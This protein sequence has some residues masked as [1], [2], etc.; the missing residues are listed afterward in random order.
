MISRVIPFHYTHVIMNI[1]IQ[2]HTCILLRTSLTKNSLSLFVSTYT[3]DPQ[4]NF[5]KT[6]HEL[7]MSIYLK[8]QL[9]FFSN[10]SSAQL[11]SLD[12]YIEIT[13][14]LTSNRHYI[15]LPY[16]C[17][18]KCIGTDVIWISTQLISLDVLS[19]RHY[20]NIVSMSF[21]LN[22][23]FSFQYTSTPKDRK[24]IFHTIL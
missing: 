19:N 7:N 10:W 12:V 22:Y 2:F 21:K 24:K 13:S 11:I 17:L 20:I 15:Y 23:L 3:I 1:S 5:R 8:R 16:W 14:R 9:K 6:P 18:K 4:F